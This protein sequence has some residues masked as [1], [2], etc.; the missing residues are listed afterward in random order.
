MAPSLPSTLYTGNDG[1]IY[2][3]TDSGSTWTSLNGP[4]F[5]A[6][7]FE[8]IAYHPSDRQFMIGGT[9]DNGTLMKRADGT[10][11]EAD[12]G[13]GGSSLIDRNAVDTVT[14]DM[15]HT[16][17]NRS[18]P[19]GFIGLERAHT[20]ACASQ[21]SW[22]FRGCGQ[23]PTSQLDCD[24]VPY[25]DTNGI[26]CNDSV[27]FYAP[28]AL[29]P[30]FPDT[31]YFGTNRL[32]RSAD[33]GDTMAPVS[34]Q[35]GF[36]VDAIGIAPDNDNIRLVG[37]DNGI[38]LTTTGA[39]TLTN[40]T[41]PIPY[42]YLI[43]RIKIDPQ[44]H[45]VAYVAIGGYGLA[46]GQHVWKTTN[47]TSGAPTWVAAGSG[48]PDVPV[49]SF[50]IDG[51]DT[52]N[53]FAGT[54]I[55]VFA[56]TD[57]GAS[58]TP[59]SNGLPRV[60]VFDMAFQDANKVLRIATHGR[61]IWEVQFSNVTSQP[62]SFFT[63]APCR[64]LDTR[65][66]GQP[67]VSLVARTITIAGSCGIPA[68]AKAVSAN[69]TVVQPSGAG[70]LAFYPNQGPAPNVSTINFSAGQ[71]RANNAVLA[72][73]SGGQGTL[74]VMP[75]IGSSGQGQLL[76]DVNGWFQ[77]A[78]SSSL[79]ITNIS[80]NPVPGITG[81]QV[82]TVYGSNFVQGATVTLN[83]LTFGGGPYTKPTTFYSSSQLTISANVTAENATW[84]AQVTNPDHTTSNVFPFTT[85]IPVPAISS[86]S[87]NPVPG[88]YGDQVITIYGSNFV[89]GATV[90]LNDLT[91]GGGPY[92][93][94]TT[95]YSSSQLTISANVTAENATWSAQVSNPD[96]TT[97]KAF[98]FTTQIPVPVISSISPNP[99][100]GIYG[101]QVITIYGSNFVQG[102]TVI[103]ND[104][105]YGGGP[106]TKSTTFYSSGQLTISANVTAENA[107]W[108]AQVDNPGGTASNLFYFTTQIPVP[109][110]S[111]ILPNPVPGI[112]G[113]QVITLYG[114][115][116]VQGATVI[117]N[118]LTY[119]G[120]PYTKATTFY[121]SGQLA[122][123]ANVTAEN[124]TWSAQVDNP[125]GTV[126]NLYYFSTQIPA[127]SISGIS[128]NP[129]PGI[130]AQQVVTIY[131][132][133]FVQGA[134][135]TLNDLTYGGGPYT[136]P[137]TFYGSGELTISVNVTVE[138]ALWSAQ[139]NNSG[140]ASSNVYYFTTQIP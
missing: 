51:T 42:Q 52:Q 69:V 93:K 45:D 74:Q 2:K 115:N 122:I 61:G 134:T 32:Y 110:I 83:D 94:P 28:M 18:N 63:T 7:Q 1:G 15:Y 118:D 23:T 48:I 137:T 100:P 97:S 57:G 89:Q 132:S 124:A 108:S 87:P 6:T 40:V 77:P 65:S 68:Q 121:G 81:D 26:S 127:P 54:D 24:G 140:G 22:A 129:V 128:P 47:L 46:A 44:N 14:V 120:G 101:D 31:V 109:S 11:L 102:A 12:G 105:T 17:F 82:I 86:I 36:A 71:T 76:I 49:E 135:V 103:L 75:L 123:S 88:I 59:F 106:Y 4:T 50:A 84:S 133:N 29:G 66:T 70:F 111:S 3:S 34:Q 85:Q 107:L 99:V 16:Y 33:R 64:V 131:G 41:G 136:K 9:Q 5:S 20:T 13:D 30:G 55:G 95:F 114:S 25:S 58:W 27:L 98:Q 116:F 104:L 62:L 113:D 130:Y 73:D 19:S 8:S 10:W 37:S 35:L 91:F 78:V 53:L 38:F 39:S 80:P 79:A 96:G 90:T 72:L 43:E 21:D 119:G 112:Y 67:L 125:G 126:S 60:P 139:V 117:L 56:S 92:V 138:N